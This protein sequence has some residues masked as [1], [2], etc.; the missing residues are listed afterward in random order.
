[1]CAKGK[2][3][4]Q[5][6]KINVVEGKV[7]QILAFLVKTGLVSAFEHGIKETIVSTT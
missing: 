3:R 6:T 7:D 2:T 4:Q 1:M 5:S